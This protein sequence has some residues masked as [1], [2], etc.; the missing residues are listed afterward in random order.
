MYMSREGGC[1]KWSFQERNSRSHFVIMTS[2]AV[3]GAQKGE[4]LVREKKAP[5]LEWHA[6]EE[7]PQGRRRRRRREDYEG[8]KSTVGLRMNSRWI[9]ENEH[10]QK[11]A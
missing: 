2:I 11:V 1:A 10:V 9:R 3:E 7:R 4:E 5:Y 8:D 6:E